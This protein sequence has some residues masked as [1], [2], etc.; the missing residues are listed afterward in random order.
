MS[1]IHDQF[2]EVNSE[3]FE[4]MMEMSLTA[5]DNFEVGEKI[6]G[7]IVGFSSENAFIG[8]SGK[9][10]GLLSIQELQNEEGELTH[11]KGDTLEAYVVSTGRGEIRLT[12]TIGKG[13]ASPQ[14]LAMAYKHGI[15]VEGRVTAATKGGYSVSVSEVRCFCPFSQM[16]IKGAKD[17]SRFVDQSFQFKIIQY[18]ERGRNIVLSRRVLQEELQASRKE[19]LMESLNEGDT[20]SGTIQSIQTFGLFVDLGGIEGLVPK[21]EVSW[22]RH[23]NLKDF[24]TGEEVTVKVISINWDE[25]RISLS[26]KALTQNPWDTISKDDEGKTI[27]GKVVNFISSGAFVELQPGLEGFVHVSRM[28]L[29][30]RINKPEEVLSRGDMVSV[31]VLGVD[32]EE[33]RISLELL[34]D[35]PD[36]WQLPEKELL[37]SNHKGVIEASRPKGIHLRLENGMVGYVPKEE[38]SSDRGID[39]QKEFP[40]GSELT[41]AIKSINAGERRLILS[42]MGAERQAE[43]KDYENFKNNDQSQGNASLGNLFK[44]KFDQLQKD[45]EK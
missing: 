4:K 26:L 32:K 28:S 30:K 24:K 7:T 45:L 36:P 21:S 29:L 16:D 25:N 20:V 39:V 12:S 22:S 8:I 15:P 18:G 6:T 35:E 38:L 44:D 27:N 9:S 19:E 42:V 1:D 11:K 3:D 10:E 17:E 37:S 23:T 2:E 34:T 14:I 33:K 31:K 40:V 5:K 41:V 13:A 43:L